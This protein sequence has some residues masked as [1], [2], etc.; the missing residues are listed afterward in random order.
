MTPEI[1]LL[2]T[3]FAFFFALGDYLY[4]LLSFALLVLLFAGFLH[5]FFEKD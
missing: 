5:W 3:F 1:F 2:N 4:P